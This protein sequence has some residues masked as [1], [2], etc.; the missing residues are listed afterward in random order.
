MG[1]Q[2]RRIIEM[3]LFINWIKYSFG[4]SINEKL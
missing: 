4:T 3:Q 1:R 2:K